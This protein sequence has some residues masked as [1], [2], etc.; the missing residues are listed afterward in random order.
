MLILAVPLIGTSLQ[1]NLYKMH[2]L[3]TVHPVPQVQAK[4]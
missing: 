4:R 1:I 3:P 2:N